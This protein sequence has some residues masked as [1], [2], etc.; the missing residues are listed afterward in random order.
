MNGSF[1]DSL[2]FFTKS[3]RDSE[4]AVYYTTF[5]SGVC[6]NLFRINRYKQI[7]THIV[8]KPNDF[9]TICVYGHILSH[10]ISKLPL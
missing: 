9:D 1:A 7:V 8:S 3:E 10:D 2:P 5:Y 6:N 4:T